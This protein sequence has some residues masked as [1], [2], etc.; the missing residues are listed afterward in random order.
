MKKGLA[1]HIFSIVVKFSVVSMDNIPLLIKS[2]IAV[3]GA[4]N[5]YVKIVNIIP[6]TSTDEAIKKTSMESAVSS[7]DNDFIVYH[8]F[9]LYYMLLILYI[10]ICVVVV[11]GCLV[12]LVS[13]C[14]IYF[15]IVVLTIAQVV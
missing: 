3:M 13:Y 10:T 1:F 2:F 6:N 7:V 14:F 8:R 15:K 5:E 4:L 9:Y 12:I 11:L